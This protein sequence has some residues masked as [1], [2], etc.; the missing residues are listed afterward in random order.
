MISWAD[1]LI[2]DTKVG[3]TL[4][5]ER[6]VADVNY[7][8]VADAFSHAYILGWAR[9]KEE[10]KIALKAARRVKSAKKIVNYIVVRP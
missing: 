5:G 6:K 1:A 3:L 4:V 10:L 9:S 7:K 2:F 8:V